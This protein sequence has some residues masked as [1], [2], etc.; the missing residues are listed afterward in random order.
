MIKT[1]LLRR[2]EALEDQMIPDEEPT[3]LNVVFVDAATKQPTGGFKAKLGLPRPAI[4]P[5]PRPR[6]AY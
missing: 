3:F 2:L 4:A 6:R 1:N 5:R